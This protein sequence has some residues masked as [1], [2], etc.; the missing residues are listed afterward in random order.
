MICPRHCTAMVS[1]IAFVFN[2]R[3]NGWLLSHSVIPYSSD[4]RLPIQRGSNQMYGSSAID[5][6]HCTGYS[7]TEAERMITFAL[8][9]DHRSI[10]NEGTGGLLRR[11]MAAFDS[12]RKKTIQRSQGV[13]KSGKPSTCPKHAAWVTLLSHRYTVA[14]P[15]QDKLQQNYPIP[16]YPPSM[17]SVVS[18]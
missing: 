6:Y 12:E 18:F 16:F 1:I 14:N 5:S 15:N 7:A 17:F 13:S 10:K 8:S 11:I 4:P 9:G 3:A 2:V